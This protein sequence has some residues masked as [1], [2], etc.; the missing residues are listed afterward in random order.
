MKIWNNTKNL[1]IFTF[2]Y[3]CMIC[4]FLIMSGDINIYYMYLILMIINNFT[5]FFGFVTSTVTLTND[6]DS[7]YKNLS[8]IFGLVGFMNL[9]YCLYVICNLSHMTLNQEV[10]IRLFNFFIQILL[11]MLFINTHSNRNKSVLEFDSGWILIA[12]VVI[13]GNIVIAQKSDLAP[14]YQNGEYSNLK[15]LL[16]VLFILAHIYLIYRENEL[17]GKFY[18]DNMVKNIQLISIFRIGMI[19]IMLVFGGINFYKVDMDFYTMNKVSCIALTILNFL[20]AYTVYTICFRDI[21][22]RPNQKLY[23]ELLED[24]KKLQNYIEQLEY[25]KFN[26]EYYKNIYETL[27][28]NMPN[29]III[30]YL[31][32]IMFV[33]KKILTLFNLS[34]EEEIIN[35]EGVD[36]VS[37]ECRSEYIRTRDIIK[38]T[39][40][41]KFSYNNVSF[42]GEVIRFEEEIHNKKFQ[43]SIIRNIE[44]KIKLENMKRE[45]ELRDMKDYIKN[46]VLS[47]ISHE[48]KTPVNVIYSTAQIQD[49]NLANRDYEKI[50]E[51]NDIIKKN[52]NRLIR[53][54]NN[55]IES[56]KLENNNVE[57]SL[58]CVNIVSVVEDITLSIVNF[59]QKENLDVV[60]DTDQE[61]IYCEVD[62]D[63]IERIMLNLLSNAI[64]YNKKNGSIHVNIKDNK[65]DVCIEVV[66][67]GIGIPK[68]KIDTIFD[69]FK[70]FENKNAVINKGSGIGLNIVK[71]LIEAL[72][73][74]IEIDSVLDGGTTIRV[75]LNKAEYD[76]E[77]IYNVEIDIE[78]KV[79]LE[80]SDIN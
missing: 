35:L 29:G 43:V 20:Y 48:F 10:Q 60:F 56:T 45:L 31:G 17:K 75:I 19:F 32:R 28:K 34:S 21:V 77:N 33:N 16:C 57:L 71:K 63:A 4:I 22:K 23:Y 51:F 40:N 3:V 14:I 30:S 42:Q 53:L 8:K 37:D 1:L 44:D 73:G 79:K 78:E 46:E 54:I 68:E 67:T 55:F 6:D 52:C 38:N 72:N 49:I 62:I 69:R 5:T 50:T 15:N 13:I 39:V 70:R 47:N 65:D 27:F 26:L 61:E 2:L 18:D 11:Y 59:A 80:L 7:I 36:I 41:I 9:L 58:K 64:K 76:I 74:K 66:D 12:I 25:T 24:K